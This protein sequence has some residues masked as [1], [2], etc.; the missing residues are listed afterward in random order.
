MRKIREYHLCDRCNKEIDE[1]K[2]SVCYDNTYKFELCD[3]CKEIF[4]KYKEELKQ[5]D[6]KKDRIS[7]K[8]NFGKYLIKKLQE[9][10][11]QISQ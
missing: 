3:E 11:E 7:K 1:K 8:Y 5:V 4:D 9:N 2:L 10:N 6:M